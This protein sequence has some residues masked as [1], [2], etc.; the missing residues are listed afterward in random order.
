MP[1]QTV[2]VACLPTPA[3]NG[4][5]YDDH[6]QP[7]PRRPPGRFVDRTRHRAATFASI[8]PGGAVPAT[9]SDVARLAGVSIKTVSNVLNEHP[10]VRAS[11]RQRV[12]AAID[13]LQYR[14]NVS[15]R[16]LRSGRSGTIALAIPE[17]TQPYFAELAQAV[18]DVATAQG[19]TVF[20]ETTGGDPVRELEIVSGRQEIFT[21]G[22]IFSPQG[23]AP[24]DAGSITPGLPTVLLGERIF[25][26]DYDHVTMANTEAS[27][28]AVR[29][30]LDIGRR[31]IVILGAD[32]EDTT[33]GTGPLRLKG[34]ME[35]LREVGLSPDRDLLIG[36]TPWT[37]ETGAQ[38]LRHILE[39]RI[40]FDA[41]FALNDALALGALR[42]LLQSG[43]RVPDDVAIV[44]FDDTL[45]AQWATPSL[46]SVQP[47]GRRIA[48]LAV[49]LL[50][51][52]IA[53][54]REATEHDELVAPFEL[55]IRESTVGPNPFAASSRRTRSRP[56]GSPPAQLG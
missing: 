36:V 21:D 20:V 50:R 1:A 27:A 51:R 41:V 49:D 56:A 45:D 34:A 10:H 19:V 11:T 44:G 39:R 8:Y 33:T 7:Q 2:P 38:A 18:I 24:E 48:R 6:L 40:R 4:D 23:I 17:L 31:R 13:D 47:G 16:N 30:L 46:T 55:I 37:R 25:H 54:A 29:H 26:S 22:L 42:A 14:V 52:R 43:I 15:A 9:M 35:A 28:A 32:P 5:S 53:G 12:E 3:D